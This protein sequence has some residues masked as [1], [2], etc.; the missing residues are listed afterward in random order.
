MKYSL[1]AFPIVALALAC[2]CFSQDKMNP[3]PGGRDS[4]QQ[5]MPGGDAR[6]M[7]MHGHEGMGFMKENMMRGGQE[8][9]A[10][11]AP[12][13]CCMQDHRYMMRGPFMM[14]HPRAFRFCIAILLLVIALMNILLTIMVCMDMAKM[15]AFN[16]IWIPIVLILGI[17]GT[18]LYALFRIG[19]MIKAAS[20]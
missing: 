8:C 13:G 9:G 20:K 14:R 18:G 3:A 12:V 19:D 2:A 16:A 6:G 5:M 1:A 7:G 17:P 10:N 4:M 11:F 15:A